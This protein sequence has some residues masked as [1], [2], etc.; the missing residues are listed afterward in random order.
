MGTSSM[1]EE[2]A[3]REPM[4]SKKKLRIATLKEKLASNKDLAPLKLAIF[5]FYGG[6]QTVHQSFLGYIIY[7]YI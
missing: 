3:V 1:D 6:K 4:T 7:M 2:V 5:L